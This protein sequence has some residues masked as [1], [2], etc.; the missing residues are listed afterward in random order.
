MRRPD[1]VRVL[2]GQY[3]RA[4]VDT[5]NLPVDVAVVRWPS[6]GERV[7]GSA[8]GPSL[9]SMMVGEGPSSGFSYRTAMTPRRP[10]TG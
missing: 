1:L 6:S 5:A 3:Q 9:A 10:R 2:A 7:A 4:C 8:G